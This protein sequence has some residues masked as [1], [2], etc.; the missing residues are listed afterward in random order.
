MLLSEKQQSF[1]DFATK[2]DFPDLV[3]R[4][5]LKMNLKDPQTGERVKT[6]VYLCEIVEEGREKRFVSVYKPHS[7][8]APWTKRYNLVDVKQGVTGTTTLARV[9]QEVFGP[10]RTGKK[11]VEEMPVFVAPLLQG[12]DTFTGEHGLGFWEREQ[13]RVLIN[14][15]KTTV[16]HGKRTGVFICLTTLEWAEPVV[17]T[18]DLVTRSRAQETLWYP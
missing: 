13:D 10:T 9:A 8:D 18:G 6:P 15:S 14:G 11:R 12:V 16:E 5:L 17:P 1:L 2:G 4:G 3:H 7:K